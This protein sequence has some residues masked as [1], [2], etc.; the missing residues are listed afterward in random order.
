MGVCYEAPEKFSGRRIQQKALSVESGALLFNRSG[1][2]GHS[3]SARIVEQI[4]SLKKYGNAF[5]CFS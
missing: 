2:E 1:A 5:L 4:K 3:Q